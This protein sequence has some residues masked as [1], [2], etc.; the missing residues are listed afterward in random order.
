M[1]YSLEHK[2]FRI[3]IFLKGIYSFFEFIAGIA[4]LLVSSSEIS[5]FV[6]DL[7]RHELLQDPHDIIANFLINLTGNFSSSLKLFFALYLII[8]G[9]IKVGLI[10]ALW[11]KKLKVYPIAMIVFGLFI[12]YQIYRYIL[13]PSLVLLFLTDLDMAV[14]ILTWMEWKHLEKHS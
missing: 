13:H 10:I 4:L 5:N 11:F 1:K 12:I 6:K 9:T 7:F 8:H 3:T 2:F 14:I